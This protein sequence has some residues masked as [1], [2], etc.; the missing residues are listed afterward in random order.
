MLRALLAYCRDLL[1]PQKPVRIRYPRFVRRLALDRYNAVAG[2]ENQRN[3]ALT[4]ENAVWSRAARPASATSDRD[5]IDALDDIG[6]VRLIAFPTKR[7][8]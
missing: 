6:G 3:S 8:H 4:P 1:G 7:I 2:R 5:L